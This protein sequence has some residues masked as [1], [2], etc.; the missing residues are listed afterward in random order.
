MPFLRF[1][2]YDRGDDGNLVI[3]EKEAKLVRRIYGMF[4]QGKTPYCIAKQ[5]TEESIPTPDGKSKWSK[6]VIQS[7]LTNEKYKGD[8]LLQKVFTVDFL[9]KKK[10]I[11]EGEVPQYYVEGNHE[12]IIS[13]EIY[14]M[15][16][17]EFDRRR[18]LNKKD[19]EAD[20]FSS[21]IV[22]GD[23]GEFFS[24]KVWHSTN[25]YRN[26]IWRCR[27]KYEKGASCASVHLVEA[28]IRLIF[29]KSVNE[30]LLKKKKEPITEFDEKLWR[31]TVERI[32]VFSKEKICV[33]FSDGEEV[34]VGI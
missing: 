24:P 6:Q 16:Q 22:C 28:E 20:F 15:V 7:I 18:Q 21:K 14:E 10:K 26:V 32:T 8:A 2:G 25:N 11:N 5:L 13:A 4:L 17:E 31:E 30:L 3:N 27:N 33:K 34:W 29:V 9:T 1:L 23:C 19:S 12:P